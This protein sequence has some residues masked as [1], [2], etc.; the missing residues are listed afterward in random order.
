MLELSGTSSR[1]RGRRCSRP[2]PPSRAP[3]R[4]LMAAPVRAA[5][6]RGPGRGRHRRRGRGGLRAAAPGDAN[7][8]GRSRPSWRWRTRVRVARRD[9]D[10]AQRV[11]TAALAALPAQALERIALLEELAATQAARGQAAD[12]SPPRC[13]LSTRPM[14]SGVR[15]ST[16][17]GWRSCACASR[18]RRRIGR[19]AC[20]RRRSGCMS[21]R[22]ASAPCSCSSWR[23]WCC[24]GWPWRRCCCCGG[25]SAGAWPRPRARRATRPKSRTT[26]RRR[27]SWALDRQRLRS[28]ALDASDDAQFVL[29]GGDRIAAANA[30]ALALQLG[31]PATS[32]IGLAARVPELGAALAA[33]DDSGQAQAL[34]VDGWCG[35][36]SALDAGLACCACGPRPPLPRTPGGR[37]AT[38]AA[39]RGGLAQVT[40]PGALG[41]GGRSPRRRG[42]ALPRPPRRPK[43]TRSAAPWWS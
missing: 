14:R 24:W 21:W 4:P 30:A 13:A 15:P 11:L 7:T 35:R 8:P 39:L 29:E 6:A 34:A 9:L 26:A 20:W 10:G 43:A 42:G 31:A 5:G 33:L 28:C 2:S 16:I 17:P 19:S 40:Q 32:G 18:W 12:A 22:C 41:R 36:L 27:P 37:G 38:P 3:T 25:A 1:R 23:R